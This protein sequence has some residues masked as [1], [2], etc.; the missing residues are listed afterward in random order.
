MSSGGTL[1]AARLAEAPPGRLPLG[2]AALVIVLLSALLW[3]GLWK[4]AV[5][6]V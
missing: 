4:L 1:R 6:L 2:A 3:L 5:L